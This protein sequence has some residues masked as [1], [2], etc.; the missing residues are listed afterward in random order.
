MAPLGIWV[1]ILPALLALI[2]ACGS[3]YSGMTF[4]LYNCLEREFAS[5]ATGVALTVLMD[6]AFMAL[7]SV[8]RK[9]DNPTALPRF[10]PCDDCCTLAQPRLSSIVCTPNHER[11]MH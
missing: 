5:G 11:T 1:L 3:E 6:L 7:S 2:E 9:N 8:V 4:A 10:L